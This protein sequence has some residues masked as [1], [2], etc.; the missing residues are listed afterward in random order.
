MLFLSARSLPVG[1]GVGPIS[2][3]DE[4]NVIHSLA[5][6]QASTQGYDVLF[7]THGFNV[8][9]P[10][11]LQK[12]SDW[13]S[14]LSIGN[15]VVIG[16]LWPGD[17]RWIHVIDYPV[18]GNEAMAAGKLFAAAINANCSAALS[19]S[20]ASHSLGARVV[21]ET[22]SGLN[23]SVR[24]LLIMAGAIDSTCLIAEY[25]TAA[26]KVQ[27]I[28]ILASAS[29]DVLEWAFP[30]GNFVSGIFSHGLPYVH[31][32]LGR[33]GPA[34]PFPV[35][36]NVHPDWQIP[37]AWNFGHGSYLPAAAVPPPVPP[38]VLATP[39]PPPPNTPAPAD[40]AVWSAAFASLRWQ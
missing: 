37:A 17:A 11:G 25:A 19:I 6:V 35:P 16:L 14:L 28:S 20:L 34:S 8:N 9:Q 5:D 36:N 7:V 31:T 38:V 21:L 32:A 1:G 4:N 23:L 18:E 39:A 26:Q 30:T 15:T 22:L 33:E 10:D 2:V 12:L 24:R 29:D 13:S 40:T 3:L 27:Q